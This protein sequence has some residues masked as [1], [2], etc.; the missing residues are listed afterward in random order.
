MNKNTE[1]EP[2][3]PRDAIRA[4]LDGEMLYD[5]EGN[6]YSYHFVHGGF[7]RLSADGVRTDETTISK[8]HG[9]Y[10]R[11]ANPCGNYKNE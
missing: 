11:E 1:K 8:F 3:P 5:I 9:L 10:R 6:G 4:M 2:L 7:C